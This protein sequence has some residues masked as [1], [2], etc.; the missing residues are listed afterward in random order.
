MDIKGTFR[1]QKSGLFGILNNLN[2]LLLSEYHNLT[3]PIINGTKL[4]V[5]Q[6]LDTLKLERESDANPK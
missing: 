6:A 5:K 2:N 4:L 1:H 3:I